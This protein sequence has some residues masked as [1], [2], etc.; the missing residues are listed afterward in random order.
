MEI[1]CTS[2]GPKFTVKSALI[3]RITFT[4]ADKHSAA[5]V[6]L[7]AK[8]VSLM[9]LNGTYTI[10]FDPHGDRHESLLPNWNGSYLVKG[11]IVGDVFTITYRPAT[12]LPAPVPLPSE[13]DKRAAYLKAKT[14]GRVII[15]GAHATGMV[16]N[17]PPVAVPRVR[18]IDPA[19]GLNVK[20]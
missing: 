13:K 2:D 10:D 19:T 17:R 8:D 5:P 6:T 4:R 20:P 15:P 9:T 3:Q 18:S 14:E 16:D 7:A 11:L 12:P 1:V